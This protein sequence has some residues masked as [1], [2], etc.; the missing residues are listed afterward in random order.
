MCAQT[1]EAADVRVTIIPRTKAGKGPSRAM[2]CHFFTCLMWIEKKTNLT[3]Q[4]LEHMR[5]QKHRHLTDGKS[6]TRIDYPRN[7]RNVLDTRCVTTSE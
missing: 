3:G 1:A 7:R 6:Y 4:M 5:T 2:C